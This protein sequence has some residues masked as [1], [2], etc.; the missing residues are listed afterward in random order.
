MSVTAASP[1]PDINRSAMRRAVLSSV[2]GNAFEWFDF[3]IFGFFLGLITQAFFPKEDYFVATVLS[4]ATFAVSYIVRPFGGVLL[5]M[6]ADRAGRKPALTLMILMMGLSTLLI[7]ATPPYA[8]IGVAAPLLIVLARVL[9]GL[10][11]GGEFSS[12]TAMLVEYAPPKRKMLYGSLQMCSQALAIA[13]AGL[14]GYGLSSM[15]DPSAL[16]SWGW[17]VPFLLGVL[18]APVGFYIRRKVAESP[19]F[20]EAKQREARIPFAQLCTDHFGALVAGLGVCVVGTVSNYVWFIN[21][22]QYVVGK[23]KLPFSEALF[24]TFVCGLLL[25]ALCP[26]TGWLADRFGARRVLSIGAVL[27]ALMS[28]PLL[29]WV[30]AAPDMTRLLI[31]QAS[32]ALVISLIWGPTPG[33]MAGLFPTGTRSTGVAVSYNLGVLLFGGLAPLTLAV[34]IEKTGSNLM[35]AYYT[36]F[37]AALALALIGYGT[38]KN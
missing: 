16:A 38:K 17:R 27:F 24:G 9:Q 18:I 8:S 6:Y 28:W 35:P 31:A 30:M 7:G 32:I 13:C 19:S 29:A 25:C 12:A 1:A 5:G 14:F 15:L 10:S 23:L 36:I 2:I 20:V 34:L 22:P 11:A 26:V 4:T 21:M 33:M 37:C 3:L